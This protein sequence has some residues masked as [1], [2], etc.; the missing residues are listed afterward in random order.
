MTQAGSVDKRQLSP[1][2]LTRTLGQG[3]FMDSIFDSI[4]VS[5]GPAP[6]R[7][8]PEK[9]A[10]AHLEVS[11][12]TGLIATVSVPEFIRIVA[13]A[14]GAIVLVSAAMASKAGSLGKGPVAFRRYKYVFPCSGIVFVT[15]SQT[16]VTLDE[17][18]RVI[19]CSGVTYMGE[20]LS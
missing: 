16:P 17:G 10:G 8:H 13:A 12:S 14:A 2:E 1:G 11:S 6:V 15:T 3:G 7:L 5:P 4:T 18:V 9:V 20:P 19:N